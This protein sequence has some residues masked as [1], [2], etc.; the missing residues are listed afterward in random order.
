MSDIRVGGAYVDLYLKGVEKLDK[1]INSATQ[2][3]KQYAEQMKKNE[4]EKNRLNL[5]IQ[6]ATEKYSKN[7]KEVK[8]LRDKLKS[9]NE[10]QKDLKKNFKE[11]ADELDKQLKGYADL[12][13]ATQDIKTGFGSL[14]SAATLFKGVITSLAAKELYSFLIDM[15]SEIEQYLTSFTILLGSTE[16]AQDMMNDIVDIAKKTPFETTDV[17]EAIEILSQYG[18]AQDELIP[19]FKQ[20]ADLSRGN[21]DNLNNIA[22][23]YARIMNSGKVTLRELNIMIRRGVPVMQALSESTGHT[24]AE[25]YKLIRAGKLGTEELDKAI[26]Y[27]TLNGGRFE[28]LVEE[29]GKT[30]QGRIST[31]KD[32]IAYRRGDFWKFKGLYRRHYIR[33]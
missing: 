9:L 18:Q 16:A 23:A 14:T 12:G 31:L 21:A 15:N 22:L 3:L 28:G 32:Y 1:D 19:K 7:S 24:T 17:V 25:L 8:D 33:N 4:Q 2:K 11:T 13:K 10:Q 27:L 30:L 26:N 6:K 29:Q 5:Q 20:L